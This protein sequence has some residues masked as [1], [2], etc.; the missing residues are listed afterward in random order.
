MTFVFHFS[1]NYD[2][3]RKETNITME[4][5]TTNIPNVPPRVTQAD[6]ESVALKLRR[7]FE[8]MTDNERSIVRWVLSG[9][10]EHGEVFTLVAG[11]ADGLLVLF[12]SHGITVIPPGDPIP[13][14]R[15][16]IRIAIVHAETESIG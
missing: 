16:V 7:S 12:G 5:I 1:A 3:K 11:G 4:S 2:S 8:A 9:A 14:F 6:F 13:D 10:A 15:S